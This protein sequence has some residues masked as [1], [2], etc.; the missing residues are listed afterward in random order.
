MARRLSDQQ[1][2]ELRQIVWNA[3]RDNFF[4][5]GG[6]EIDV[7]ADIAMHAIDGHLPLESVNADLLEALRE[8]VLEYDGFQDGNGDPCPTLARARSAISRAESSL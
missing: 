6:A 1:W 8:F 4:S 5:E 7:L 2:R 3:F